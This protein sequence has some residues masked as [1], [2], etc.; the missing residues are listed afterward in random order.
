MVCFQLQFFL[1][2]GFCWRHF[3]EFLFRKPRPRLWFQLLDST[4]PSRQLHLQEWDS[5]LLPTSRT[6]AD[7]RLLNRPYIIKIWILG[8]CH[9]YNRV[10]IIIFT[11]QVAIS[12]RNLGCP[13]FNSNI[14]SS[15]LDNGTIRWIEGTKLRISPYRNHVITGLLGSW[16][17]YWIA[18]N[19]F[20]DLRAV[21]C[22]PS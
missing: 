21:S 20:L 22:L 10:D 11:F 13:R 2:R 3:I 18:D 14:L 5:R 9:D 4:H 12:R 7:L 8:R 16:C 15:Y 17:G 19:L 1:D 6:K